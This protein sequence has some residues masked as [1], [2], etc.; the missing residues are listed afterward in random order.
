MESSTSIG[1]LHSKVIRNDLGVELARM[2][3]DL[4]DMLCMCHNSHKTRARALYEL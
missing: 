2:E 4:G 1:M 3:Q